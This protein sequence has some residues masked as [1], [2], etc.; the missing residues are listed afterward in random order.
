MP[1]YLLFEGSF[2]LG[3]FIS[4]GYDCSEILNKHAHAKD[5]FYW[6]H[7]GQKTPQKVIVKCC[8]QFS[9]FIVISKSN[10]SAGSKIDRINAI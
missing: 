3:E 1:Y 5:G 2:T 7:L 10:I 9:F 6:I 8:V 4:P